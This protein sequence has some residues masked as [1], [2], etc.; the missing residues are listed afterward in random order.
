MPKGIKLAT[1]PVSW[2]V[3]H[4]GRPDLP[5]WSVVLDQIADAGFHYTELGPLGYLPEEPRLIREEMQKRQLQVVGA[6]LLAPLGDA[7]NR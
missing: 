2:G 1:A 6:A 5:P 4:M 3:D 7:Q